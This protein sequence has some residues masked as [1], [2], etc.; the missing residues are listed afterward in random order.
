MSSEPSLKTDMTGSSRRSYRHP[1]PEASSTF[2]PQNPPSWNLF[3]AKGHT[4]RV[5]EGLKERLQAIRWVVVTSGREHG[6]PAIGWMETLSAPKN[7]PASS[8]GIG[9]RHGQR[10]ISCTRTTRELPR[11]VGYEREN[12]V[13]MVG[14][15]RDIRRRHFL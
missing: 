10:L 2:S 12:V 5:L 8:G 11:P 7:R 4:R 6:S 3:P 13:S 14:P 9:S 1:F 15:K